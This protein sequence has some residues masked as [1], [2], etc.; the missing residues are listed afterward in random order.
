MVFW[1]KRG[2]QGGAKTAE[3]AGSELEWWDAVA[4]HAKKSPDAV[5]LRVQGKTVTYGELNARTERLLHAFGRLGLRGG[6]T[7]VSVLPT[8]Q[9]A[10][11]VALASARADLVLVPFPPSTRIDQLVAALADISPS[12]VVAKDAIWAQVM[13]RLPASEATPAILR[14]EEDCPV[15]CRCV[16]GLREEYN[17]ALALATP[18]TTA[19]VPGVRLGYYRASSRAGVPGT[20]EVTTWDPHVVVAARRRHAR[21]WGWS[22]DDVYLLTGIHQPGPGGWL[23]LAFE[24][25]AATVVMESWDPVEWLSTVERERVTRSFL[26][27]QKFRSLLEL[28][29]EVWGEADISSL[30]MVAHGGTPCPVALKL[31]IIERFAPAEV[32]EMFGSIG[33]MLTRI[34]TTEWVLHP[35]SVGKA[36]Q[37]VEI[38]VVGPDG[39]PVPPGHMGRIT[40]AP[41]RRS[42]GGEAADQAGKSNR[43]DDIDALMAG[44]GGGEGFVGYMDEEGYLYVTDRNAECVSR[45]GVSVYPW[46]VEEVLHGHPAVRDCV[47]FPAVTGDGEV[48]VAAVE[49]CRGTEVDVLVEHC[50]RYLTKAKCPDRIVMVES[51]ERDEAGGLSRAA[52]AASFQLGSGIFASREAGDFDAASVACSPEAVGDSFPNA[53]GRDRASLSN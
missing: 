49:A 33:T 48:L 37:D 23:H 6:D 35:G 13:E 44:A 20:L 10:I 30:R 39:N 1:R 52:L 14:V 9:E 17:E 28:P 36:L 15:L 12:L 22:A 11:E 7:V 32:Y 3:E 53:P 4:A 42:R 40:W 5:A 27:P 8:S 34:S 21:L 45:G 25:G 2:T 16:P 31:K 19:F 43:R 50:R 29:E 47:V 26:T 24:A 51:L 41:A 46:E 38:S 18:S